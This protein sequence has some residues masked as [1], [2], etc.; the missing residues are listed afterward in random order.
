MSLLNKLTEKNIKYDELSEK[1]ILAALHKH[2]NIP[3]L[4]RT[5]IGPNAYIHSSS[6]ENFCA[7]RAAILDKT[8]SVPRE[9]VQGSM[10]IVWKIGRAVETHIREALISSLGKKNFYGEWSCKC[11]SLKHRGQWADKTCSVCNTQANDYNELTIYN[12]EY[13]IANNPDLVSVSK[14]KQHMVTEIKSMNGPDFDK[15]EE[16]LTSHVRQANRYVRFKRMN[17]DITSGKVSIIYARKD[18]LYNGVYKVFTVDV[19]TKAFETVFNE[20]LDQAKKLR[21]YFK[22]EELP[23]REFCASAMSPMAKKCPA[24]NDCFK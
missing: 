10:K 20:E 6:L 11:G 16:P 7:R 23:E 14:N 3:Q 5:P 24:C 17:G 8:N 9:Y 22:T 19:D 21:E 18:F 4:L 15:L 2:D 1:V 13:K 12:E